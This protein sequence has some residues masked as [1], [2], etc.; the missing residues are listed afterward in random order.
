MSLYDASLF[1]SREFVTHQHISSPFEIVSQ[2]AVSLVSQRI[3]MGFQLYNGAS[4]TVLLSTVWRTVWITKY[5]GSEKRKPRLSAPEN[6]CCGRNQE[7]E[8]DQ[9]A[10]E[11]LD[12]YHLKQAG[13]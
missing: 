3:L 9:A 13:S 10:A 6:D 2:T 5:T 1:Y 7:N 12:P 11:E 8:Q 4:P